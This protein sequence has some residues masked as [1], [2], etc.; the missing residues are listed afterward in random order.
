MTSPDEG[1]A[2]GPGEAFGSAGIRTLLSVFLQGDP[3]QVL[4][5]REIL[6]DMQESAFGM[7]LFVA[8]LPAFIPL[9]GVSGA[10]SGPLVALVGLQ[11]LLGLRRPWLPGPIG[12]RGPRR[13]T[14]GRF[15]ARISPLLRRLDR[16]LAPRWRVLVAPLPA[17]LAC[18][19]QLVVLGILLSLPIP[20]TNY[21]FGV[22]LLLY[23]LALL[24]RD[25]RLMAVAWTAGL[26]SI[27]ATALASG[28]LIGLGRDLLHRLH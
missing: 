7:F 11:L 17:R 25:G 23:A 27:A 21:L 1:N 10:V 24:E 9:P 5:L 26:A 3:D 16:L 22:I 12:R 13:R 28:G 15:V 4:S 18:G 20:M 2:P 8:I 14:V 6:A 19:A